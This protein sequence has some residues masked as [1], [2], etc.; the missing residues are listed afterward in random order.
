MINDDDL[1]DPMSEDDRRH[2]DFENSSKDEDVDDGTNVNETAVENDD[3]GEDILVEEAEAEDDSATIKPFEED[4]PAMELHHTQ[5]RAWVELA[6]SV[7]FTGYVALNHKDVLGLDST[8]STYTACECWLNLVGYYSSTGIEILGLPVAD[9]L[10]L[11][12]D[13]LDVADA[14]EA[15]IDSMYHVLM[16]CLPEEEEEDADEWEEETQCHIFK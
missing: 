11:V 10:K 13:L 16:D 9:Q 5:A 4:D 14:S 8:W 3:I 12:Q 15:N 2:G 7:G 6:A 1:Y